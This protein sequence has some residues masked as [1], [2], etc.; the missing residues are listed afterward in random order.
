MPGIG[1]MLVWLVA[2]SPP[3]PAPMRY[4]YNA[5][6]STLDRRY[7]YQWTILDTAL[8]KTVREWGPYALEAA[9][10]MSEARQE[11]ELEHDS[12]KLSVMYLGTTPAMERD[13]LPIR[14]PVD[15]NLGGYCVF[16]IRREQAARFRGL[17]KLAD[18]KA[19]RFGLGLGWIDVD[20]LRHNGLQVVTGSSYDGLFDMLNNQRFDVFLRAAVEVLDEYEQRRVD[21]P[22]LAIEDSLLVYYPMPMYFWFA[23]T[24]EGQRLKAR[25]EQGMRAMIADGTYDRL[26]E[27]FQGDKIRRLHLSDRHIIALE[28]P[29]LG[30]ETPFADKRLWF[31]PE[32][33]RA[34][35]AR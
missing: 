19:V 5:P 31:T 7:L 34:E 33:Y 23:K 1:A 27:Q 6:E 2:V 25:A 14:I 4:R 11:F 24:P 20:I 8:Q 30:P 3:S 28:N 29:L 26:F 35:A 16:L 17:L 22:A 9:E 12:G 32:S 21:L 15:K 13:L 10:P 18:L